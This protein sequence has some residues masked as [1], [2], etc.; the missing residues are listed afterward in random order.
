MAIVCLRQPL[1]RLA[2]D[3]AD[4]EVAGATVGDAARALERAQPAMK[5]GSSTSAGVMRRHINVFVNGERGGAGR[6]RSATTTASTSSPRSREGVNDR[7]AGRHQEGPVRARGRA[8]RR[9]SR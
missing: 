7:A 9:R 1:K 2:G 6:A 8:G 4:H 5:A 3:R